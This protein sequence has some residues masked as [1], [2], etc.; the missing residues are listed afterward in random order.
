MNDRLGVNDAD[1]YG[2]DRMH[3][4]GDGVPI[5]SLNGSINSAKLQNRLAEL[6]QKEEDARKA[7]ERSGKDL[8]VARVAQDKAN[9]GVGNVKSAREEAAANLARK[10]RESKL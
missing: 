6:R 10:N 8:E 7:S 5:E 1:N 2:S 3:R 9:E 4:T